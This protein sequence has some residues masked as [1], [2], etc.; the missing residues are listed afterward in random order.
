MKILLALDIVRDYLASSVRKED[1]MILFN[2]M[3]DVGDQRFIE[4]GTKQ[5]LYLNKYIR[6][7]T[8]IPIPNC[9][10]VNSSG[11]PQMDEKTK[12]RMKSMIN[13]AIKQI[14]N[15]NKIRGEKENNLIASKGFEF[16]TYF[17]QFHLL[18]N[19]I[20]DI[21]ISDD[22]LFHQLA[23]DQGIPNLIMTSENYMEQLAS[24][25]SKIFNEPYSIKKMKIKD[26]DVN[27]PFF[28]S[29]RDEYIGF[30][31]WFKRNADSYAYVTMNEDKEI[32]S[33]L[34]L[35]LECKID[36]YRDIT[37]KFKEARRLKISSYKVMLN[38]VK[39]GEAFFW[40]IFGE[41]VRQHVEE[42]YVTV[43]DTYSNRRRLI[44][45]MER[46]GFKY[47]GIKNEKELV[48]VKDFRKKSCDKYRLSYPFHSIGQ[49]NFI[50]PLTAKYEDELFGD[51]Q[52]KSGIFNNPIRKVLLLRQCFIPKGSLIFFYSKKKKMIINVGLSEYCRNDF[53]SCQELL[54][55]TQRR[56]SFSFSQLKELWEIKSDKKIN[57][58]KFLNICHLSEQDSL[59][60]LNNLQKANIFVEEDIVSLDP[61]L[62]KRLIHGTDY[63]KDFVIN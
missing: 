40:I 39:I 23:K 24:N 57:A 36:D 35:K 22:F 26:L 10:D 63:E 29:F 62:F 46:W 7:E 18:N 44:S 27:Q 19:K 12:S 4:K 43:F 6:S 50:V 8:S 56:T 42:L 60:I 41:A 49:V 21:I 37:P 52:Y 31:E 51:Y 55:F 20:A 30:N 45:R 16:F 11:I 2:K 58:I 54:V 34:R 15:D 47:Y 17:Y 14:K 59:F 1:L 25:N 38:G 5:Y 48:Y 61:E 33:F 13:E 32:T 3:D 9:H 28:D 53:D